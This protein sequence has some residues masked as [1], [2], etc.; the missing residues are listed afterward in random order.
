[1]K[2]Y[3]IKILASGLLLSGCSSFD[4]VEERVYLKWNYDYSSD[5][6]HAVT[7]RNR[8]STTNNGKCNVHYSEFEVIESFKG[9]FEAGDIIEASGITAHEYTNE[10][11]EQFLLLKP[12]VATGHPGYGECSNEVYEEYLSIH[13]WCCSINTEGERSLVMYDMVNSE[14]SGP[15]YLVPVRGV[16]SELRKFKHEKSSKN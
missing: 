14:Q 2:K 4:K 5:V 16:F 12:F 8:V 15:R 6:V 11:S 9:K 7:L 1:M 10:G 3:I 13:N